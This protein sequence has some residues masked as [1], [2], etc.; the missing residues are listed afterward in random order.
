VV[1]GGQFNPAI[2]FGMWTARRIGTLRGVSYVAVQLLG[3]L[4]AWQLYQYMTGRA[5]PAKTVTYST[6]MWVAEVVGTFVLAL[7][8]TAAI[9]RGFDML[10]G[11]LAYG[12]SFFA[13]IM[14]AA[15]ASAAYL[16]PAIALGVRSWSAVYVLGPLVGGLIGVNVY[17]WLLAGPAK[18]AWRRPTWLRR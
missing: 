14:I 3:G 11:G 1:S 16:N 18:G 5:L 9:T 8:I 15:V 12:A 4:A 13:G 17:S 6:P 2:T 7:G 10:Q